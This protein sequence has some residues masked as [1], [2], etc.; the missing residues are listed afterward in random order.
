MRVLIAVLAIAMSMPVISIPTPSDAQ[1]M[2]RN[3]MRQARPRVTRE[4]R[5]TNLRYEAEDRLMEIEER[6]S[7]IE[8]AGET[9]GSLTAGQQRELA[10]LNQR[11]EREQR[12]I[13]RLTA[14]LGS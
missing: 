2:G 7:S 12:E 3:S 13:E 14:A 8:T 6:I 5:L 10:Q 11:R 9:A 4:D 1:T